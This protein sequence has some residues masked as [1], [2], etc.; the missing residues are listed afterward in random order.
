MQG[1]VD[2]HLERVA[3]HQVVLRFRQG[4]KLLRGIGPDR[5]EVRELGNPL[6]GAHHRDQQTPALLVAS[7]GGEQV[8]FD[9]AVDAITPEDL[10]ASRPGRLAGRPLAPGKPAY[11]T[12]L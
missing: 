3:R 5:I 9:Q 10:L 6:A 8:G 7:N 11:S 2:L 4:G 12:S 1:L